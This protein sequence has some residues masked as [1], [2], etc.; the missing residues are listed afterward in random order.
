MTLATD[1][2]FQ[3]SSYC[4]GPG[5][6]LMEVQEP[7]WPEYPGGVASMAAFQKPLL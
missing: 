5:A 3:Q 4:R 6:S 2:K 7:V 1:D